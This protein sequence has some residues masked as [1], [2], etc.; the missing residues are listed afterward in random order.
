MG[1]IK[2]PSKDMI[3]DLQN[4]EM[5]YK[6]IK[7][8]FGEKGTTVVVNNNHTLITDFLLMGF[9]S[10][11]ELRILLSSLLVVA[12]CVTLFV[13]ILIIVLVIHSQILQSPMYFFLT[14]LST[15]DILLTTN[16]VPNMLPVL[17]KDGETIAFSGCITQFYIFGAT[18]TLECLLLTVMSY[19]RY[20]AICYPLRYPVLINRLICQK[21]AIISWIISYSLILI[22][23]ITLSKLEYCRSNIIDH[24]FC[25]L[26]PLLKLSCS[27][28]YI[29]QLEVSLLCIPLVVIPFIII[30]T[31]YV[32]II[33]AILKIQSKAGR[34]KTFSTCSSHLTVVILFYGILIGIYGLPNG[35]QTLNINKFLSL[36]YTVLTPLV[37]PI[38][39]SLRNQDI[40]K[41]LEK[42]KPSLGF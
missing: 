12:Y 36:S 28:T 26:A 33:L 14:H 22:D 1:K 27:D 7:K 20:L 8:T 23:T 35:G 15:N 32:C 19:D 11:K 18:E 2:V 17:L 37:N 3:L 16:I 10:S 24:F 4:A 30:V 40:R 38:I 25:D 9:N 42:M 5:G 34:Q 39:Y 29:I 31:S 6:T 13:N 41:A 21:L